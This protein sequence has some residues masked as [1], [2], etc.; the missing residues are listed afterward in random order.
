MANYNGYTSAE[1]NHALCRKDLDFIPNGNFISNG[2]EESQN[3]QF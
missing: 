1:K 2:Y 3:M